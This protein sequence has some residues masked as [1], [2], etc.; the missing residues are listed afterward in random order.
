LLLPKGFSKF[1][2]VEVR[3]MP[4]RRGV[5]VNNVKEWK[6][7]KQSSSQEQAAGGHADSF[8]QSNSTLSAAGT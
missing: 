5:V 7:P 2:G 8:H 4:N 1:S 6:K 3:L